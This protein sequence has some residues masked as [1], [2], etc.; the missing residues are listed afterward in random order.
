MIINHSKAQKNSTSLLSGI[1]DVLLHRLYDFKSLCKCIT[2][3][4]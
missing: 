2:K 3:L 4:I 1:Y